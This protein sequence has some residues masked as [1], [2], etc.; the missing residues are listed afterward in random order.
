MIPGPVISSPTTS[1]A[2]TPTVSSFAPGISRSA[3]PSTAPLPRASPSVS[4]S[5]LTVTV[6]RRSVRL[7]TRTRTWGWIR[8]VDMTVDV[9]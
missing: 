8:G 3:T 4:L 1:T 5:S 9:E 6:T 2:T 7:C